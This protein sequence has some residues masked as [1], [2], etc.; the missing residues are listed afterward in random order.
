MCRLDLFYLRVRNELSEQNGP[1][2][3]K[4]VDIPDI[5]DTNPKVKQA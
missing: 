1:F 2:L 4:T 3:L 5:P